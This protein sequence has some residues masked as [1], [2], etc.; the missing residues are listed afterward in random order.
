[1]NRTKV[2]FF[3][4]LQENVGPVDKDTDLL[5][6]N[7]I[8]NVGSGYSNATGRFTAPVDGTYSFSVTIAAQAK[9]RATASTRV[10]DEGWDSAHD[11]KLEETGDHQE[12]SS[13]TTSTPTTDGLSVFGVAKVLE[14]PAVGKGERVKSKQ[15]GKGRKNGGK[16]GDKTK[17]QGRRGKGKGKIGRETER[18]DKDEVK[19]L[20]L[21]SVADEKHGGHAERENT[22]DKQAGHGKEKETVVEVVVGDPKVAVTATS[23]KSRV[24][25]NATTTGKAGQRYG[26]C[27]GESGH[28]GSPSLGEGNRRTGGQMGTGGQADQTNKGKER[29]GQMKSSFNSAPTVFPWLTAGR[30]GKTLL[31]NFIILSLITKLVYLDLT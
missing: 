11:G 21:E 30:T 26:P 24:T 29:T 17:G 12:E 7:V 14:A 18:F 22:R 31:C 23:Q 19:S 16:K 3:A 8:T 6:G 13:S 2:A 25:Y 28:K 10:F 15:P 20:Q 5:L 9:R 4:G 1:M 27:D